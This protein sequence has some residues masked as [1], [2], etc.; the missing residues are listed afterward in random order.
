MP[1]K[2][3]TIFIK[4]MACFVKFTKREFETVCER[5]DILEV[6]YT[7]QIK[8]LLTGEIIKN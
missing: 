7:T 4:G 5:M 1:V 3:Y 2:E 6:K 8:N